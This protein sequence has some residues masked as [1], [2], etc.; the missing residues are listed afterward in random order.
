MG[1]ETDTVKPVMAGCWDVCPRKNV[2]QDIAIAIVSMSA[3]Y[4]TML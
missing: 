2:V 1:P 3:T 4:H